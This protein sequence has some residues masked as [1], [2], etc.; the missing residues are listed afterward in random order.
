[1]AKN[2]YIGEYP[3]IGI[4][5]I[6]DGRRGPLKVRESLEDQ[7]M[8]MARSA[9][10]LFEE[11]LRYSNG[12]PVKVVIADTTIGRVAEAAACEEK[13]RREGVA[14]PLRNTLLVLRRRDHGYGP[15][16]HQSGLGS[17]CY[18]ASG[19]CVPCLRAGNSCTERSACLRYLR[20]RRAGCG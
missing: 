9:A 2:R 20:P 19:R 14:I 12:E 4:R 1:M 13:F 6:I 5:P 3:V 17:E 18:R 11:N 8:N 7:T 15:Q 10:K 16:H